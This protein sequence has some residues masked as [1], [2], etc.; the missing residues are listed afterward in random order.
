M[1]FLSPLVGYLGSALLNSSIHVRFGQRGVAFLAPI[2]RTIAYIVT[3]QH[4]PYPVLVLF[5]I[6][7]GFGNGLEDGAW[8]AY[9]GNMHNANEILGS[10]HG[11]YGLG[12]VVSPLIATTMI[13][14]G[15]LSWYKFYYLMIGISLIELVAAVTAFWA[16]NGKKFRDEHPGTSDKAGGRTKEALRNRVVWICAVFLFIDEG[17]EVALGGWVV[18]FEMNIRHAAPFAAG[19]SETGFWLGMMLGRVILGF[20][21]GKIGEKLAILVSANTLRFLIHCTKAIPLIHDL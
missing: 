13:T 17:I 19:M 18:V 3:S 2:C 1:I 20:V 6:L 9:I 5:Y 10:L 8:N 15:H 4:P 14:K 12:G 16:V 7:A 11:F 21:T